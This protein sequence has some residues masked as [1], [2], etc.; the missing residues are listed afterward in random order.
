[1]T[2]LYQPECITAVNILSFTLPVWPVRTARSGAFI[3]FEPAP[4]Q[5]V[6]DIFFSAF[7]VTCLVCIFNPQNKL[8]T[9]LMG[10]KIIV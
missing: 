2:V 5:A 6:I 1:M 10:K 3:G 7:N 9:L 4:F 8:T